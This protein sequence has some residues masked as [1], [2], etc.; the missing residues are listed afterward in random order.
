M[1][2]YLCHRVARMYLAYDINGSSWRNGVSLII[3]GASNGVMVWP[4]V[5]IINGS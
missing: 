5:S 1:S 3:N 4:Y 2:A